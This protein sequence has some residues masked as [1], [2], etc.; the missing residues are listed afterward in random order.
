[1]ARDSQRGRNNDG[2]GYVASLLYTSVL[3]SSDFVILNVVQVPY[4]V[5]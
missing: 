5:C 3:E 2:L 1:M 4:P